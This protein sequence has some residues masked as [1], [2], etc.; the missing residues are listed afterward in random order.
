MENVRYLH[1]LYTKTELARRYGITTTALKKWYRFAGIIPPKKKGGY[2]TNDSVEAA[3]YFY[4]ATRYRRLTH[5]EY[6]TDV[7]PAGGLNDYLLKA[8]LM[9]LEEFIFRYIPEETRKND[10]VVRDVLERIRGHEAHQSNGF[11]VASVA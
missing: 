3:D 7:L 10:V 8:N 9:S 4:I 1:R 2:F 11:S 5:S 6:L